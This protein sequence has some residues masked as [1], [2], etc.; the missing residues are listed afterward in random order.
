MIY[1]NKT[2]LGL[3]VAKGYISGTLGQM[4]VLT[5]G[6]KMNDRQKEIINNLSEAD[7]IIETCRTNLKNL[8]AHASQLQ[9]ENVTLNLT[10]IE[11]RYKIEKLQEQIEELKDLL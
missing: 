1:L 8:D 3:F 6:K 9:K 2:Y 4:K 11:Q 10:L 5:H 7:T